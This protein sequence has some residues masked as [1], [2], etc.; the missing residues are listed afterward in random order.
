MRPSWAAENRRTRLKKWTSCLRALRLYGISLEDYNACKGMIEQSNRITARYISVCGLVLLFIFNI[1]AWSTDFLAPFQ[2][3]YTGAF[4]GLLLTLLLLQKSHLSATLIVY[5]QMLIIYA[6][7]T[8]LA[9][10]VPE[11]RGTVSLI[12]IPLL[13]AVMI[14][15]LERLAVVN[16]LFTAAYCCLVM[17][18]KAKR[19][20]GYEAFS[21]L[22]AFVL[23]LLFHDAIQSGM[24][25]RMLTEAKNKELI[26][27]LRLAGDDL[28]TK[29]ETDMMTGLYNRSALIE[30]VQTALMRMQSGVS[31]LCILDI[32]NFKEVNDTYGHQRGD[33]I[34][35]GIAHMMKN[36]FQL[37]D[38]VGRLGGDEFMV[39]LSGFEEQKQLLQRMEDFH[40]S[41]AVSAENSQPISTSIGVA[42]ITDHTIGFDE[43]YK[44]ADAALYEAKRAGKNRIH[45]VKAEPHSDRE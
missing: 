18:Y 32:D 1:I 36:A 7:S 4:L 39:Y 8:G 10:A 16:L 27:R 15:R 33:E 35:T 44:Q 9:L 42:I 5:V 30:R 23:S 11:E 13:S 41:L 43:L 34:L 29:A 26:E 25:R 38:M 31:A 6:F 17:A 37:T 2:F 22:V 40:R 12:V 45:A 19:L 3:L 20:I 14:D 24:I 28:R 21:I